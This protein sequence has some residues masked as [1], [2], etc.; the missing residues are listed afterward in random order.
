MV[1]VFN[2]EGKSGGRGKRSL[3]NQL[4]KQN[5]KMTECPRTVDK[6]RIR[7]LMKL[8]VK[9]RERGNKRD[10]TIKGKEI[11]RVKAFIFVAEELI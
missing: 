2:A 1:L 5:V 11:K 10:G 3:S 6:L 9:E 4:D 7:T 8:D